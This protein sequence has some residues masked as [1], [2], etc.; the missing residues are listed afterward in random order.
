MQEIVKSKRTRTI[1]ILMTI[2]LTAGVLGGLL[3]IGG[4]AL[5]V[6]SLVFFLAFSQHKAH[7][8]SLAVVVFLSLT[9]VLS[10]ASHGYINWLLAAEMAVGGV[11]GATLG[12]RIVGALKG[13]VLRRI[14]A[15]FL[16][17]V[18]IKMIADGITGGQM[19]ASQM[20]WH[21]DKLAWSAAALGTGILTGFLSAILGIGGGL[22][23]V[24]SM[25][26]LLGVPQ[27]TAQGVSLAAMLP[28]AFTGSL[29]HR[30]LGN[31]E[32]RV[33]WWIGCGAVPGALFGAYLAKSLDAQ[34]LKLGFG[35]FLMLMAVLMALK[36]AK[37]GD[38]SPPK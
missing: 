21:A 22:I 30:K 32:S 1:Y 38:A 8:T 9:S 29:I 16:I 3:G 11:I 25:V 7:G 23:M 27:H 2:G 18:G 26:M 36:E 20:A 10:Y 4:G 37:K 5:V 28:T 15:C 14:F 19:A 13:K 6:P 12:G 17:L 33:A 24:P 35:V 34:A 31:V